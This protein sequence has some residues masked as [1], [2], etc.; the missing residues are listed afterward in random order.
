MLIKMIFDHNLNVS[1]NSYEFNKK[2]QLNKK[3]ENS[4]ISNFFDVVEVVVSVV[5][6][7]SVVGSIKILYNFS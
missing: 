6:V 1:K 4:A 7:V 2:S 3:I 5:S